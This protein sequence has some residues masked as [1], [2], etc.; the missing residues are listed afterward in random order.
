MDQAAQQH[1]REPFISSLLCFHFCYIIYAYL[2]QIHKPPTLK[3]CLQCAGTTTTSILCF[4]AHNYIVLFSNRLVL[5][6][7]SLKRVGMFS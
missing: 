1:E 4:I 6:V 7:C 2:G 3:H 5:Q